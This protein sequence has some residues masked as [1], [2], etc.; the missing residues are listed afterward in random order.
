MRARHA[1][2]SA[3]ALIMTAACAP[4]VSGAGD[5]ARGAAATHCNEREVVL[6]SCRFGPA[7]GSVCASEGAIR[8]RYGPPGEPEIEL[9]GADDWS[10]VR[11]G[12]VVGQG[13]GHQSHVRF[14]S[15]DR[16]YI[17]YEGENGTLAERPGVRHSGVYIGSGADAG[18]EVA[19]HQCRG[20][21]VLLGNWRDMVQD[22]APPALLEAGILEEEPGGPFDAWF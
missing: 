22:H 18:N 21:P 19:H 12:S 17:I 4:A 8:Y 9:A 11:I 6:Y 2:T 14:T 20:S 1:I 5:A 10:N 13:G 16:H 3:A 7:I 15:G